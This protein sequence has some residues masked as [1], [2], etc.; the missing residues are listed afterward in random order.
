M[1]FVLRRSY[2]YIERE[3]LF[4]QDVV[5]KSENPPVLGFKNPKGGIYIRVIHFIPFPS[6]VCLQQLLSSP[7]AK[8]LQLLD[9]SECSVKPGSSW[10]I[11]DHRGS[12][13]WVSSPHFIH[14]K[15]GTKMLKSGWKWRI[16]KQFFFHIMELGFKNQSFIISWRSD[17]I[18]PWNPFI[19][20]PKKAIAGY[21][22]PRHWSS[23]GD[24]SGKLPTKLRVLLA[25]P[26]GTRFA[27]SPS[28]MVPEI[29]ASRN[30]RSSLFF[31]LF[32]SFSI[33]ISWF[34]IK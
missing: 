2:I 8:Q 28:K 11:L 25:G 15:V 18:W 24:A 31:Y 9:L 22:M 20:T 7:W 21:R 19:F 27:A 6:Q 3:S 16:T 1:H 30:G 4:V 34:S 23:W 33:F 5:Y 32:L 14:W 29:Q 17:E 26:D 12:L 10:I 13:N